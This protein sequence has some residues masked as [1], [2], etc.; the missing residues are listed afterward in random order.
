MTRPHRRVRTVGIAAA[1]LLVVAGTATA[2]PAVAAS[3]PSSGGQGAAG[4]VR[5]ATFNASLN[6][7]AEGALVSDLSAPG[8]AQADAVAEIIQRANPDVLLI[9]EFDYVAG[10]EA[11]RLFQDNY[12]SVPHGD[13][14]P[15][16]YPYRYTAP[17][18]TGVPSGFDL[19]NNGA[20]GGG[21]DAWGFGLFPGQYGMAVYSKLP[22]DEDAVRTFRNFRWVDMPGALLPDDPATDAPADWYSPEEL[23][24]FPL[25]SKSHWD[26]PIRVSK[27]KTVHFLVSHPTPPTFDGAEDRNG[28]RN[29]DE[30]RFWSDY[31]TGG[32]A[33][34]YITDDAG[35][36][37]GL[38]GGSLFVIAGDQNAD[39]NDGDSTGGAIR[40]LLENPRINTSTVP[41]SAGAAEATELQGGVNLDHVGAPQQDTADFSEPPGNLR[42]DY[43]L[44]SRQIRVLGSGVFWPASDEPL[45][46]LTGTYPFPS[47][48]HR[49]VW[50]DAGVPGARR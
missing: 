11:L 24:Q 42:V 38:K 1:L 36:A 33:S 22:I 12:L 20:V 49:L 30:I 13:A 28:T 6:R 23:A 34:A 18:N 45:S 9:N 31:V 16:E 44:P 3:S 46:A 26:V 10:G 2:A 4:D 35:R 19:N 32:D 50:I 37:G 25:S 41:T 21:D 40:Q 14:A 39:P 47:S 29:H 7:G 15:V 48:D 27:N 43:V 5:F 17:V 8:N